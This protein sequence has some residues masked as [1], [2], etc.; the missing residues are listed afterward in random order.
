MN[1]TFSAAAIPPRFGMAARTDEGKKFGQ[2]AKKLTNEEETPYIKGSSALHQALIEVTTDLKN[3][4]NPYRD[5]ARFLD[6]YTILSNKLTSEDLETAEAQPEFQIKDKALAKASQRKLSNYSASEIMTTV[7][8]SKELL[9]PETEKTLSKMGQKHL[10]G[11][12]A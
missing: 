5:V 1:L 11:L 6:K 10:A 8:K 12:I 2:A 4:D 3:S 7:S 9:P